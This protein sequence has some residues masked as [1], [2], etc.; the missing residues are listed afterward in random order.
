MFRAVCHTEW[1]NCFDSQLVDVADRQ[2]ENVFS[3][4]CDPHV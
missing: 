3:D 4:R 2:I 1:V